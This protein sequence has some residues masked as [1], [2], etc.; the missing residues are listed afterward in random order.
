MNIE[1]LC[2]FEDVLEA[3]LKVDILDEK[4]IEAWK[5]QRS[6]MQSMFEDS[7]NFTAFMDQNNLVN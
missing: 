1:G 3:I 5:L 2:T 7:R 6:G 4:D